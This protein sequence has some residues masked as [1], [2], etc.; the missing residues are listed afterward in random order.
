MIKIEHF[1]KSGSGTELIYV[2]NEIISKTEIVELPSKINV[3]RN[4]Y[5]PVTHIGLTPRRD[6]RSDYEKWY[7][8]YNYSY[9]PSTSFDSLPVTISPN[10]KK[11]II[12]ST[13][14]KIGDRAF[15]NAVDI[16]FEIDENNKFY[17]VIDNKIID[18]KNNKIIWPVTK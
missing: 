14:E 7:D 6:T 16:I 15:E 8:S 10:I 2:I 3:F 12:P 5:K 11:I 18:I 1:Y 13:I 17:K 9:N 4:E